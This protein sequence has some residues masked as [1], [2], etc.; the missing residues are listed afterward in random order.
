MWRLRLFTEY[1]RSLAGNGNIYFL[2]S[3]DIKCDFFFFLKI[4]CFFFFNYSY[5]KCNK[6]K[7]TFMKKMCVLLQNDNFCER[8]FL[9]RNKFFWLLVNSYIIALALTPFPLNLNNRWNFKIIL[10]KKEISKCLF[11]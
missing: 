9:P 11:F 6:L 2:K 8:I 4:L 3:C 1:F 5:C 7:I 10:F